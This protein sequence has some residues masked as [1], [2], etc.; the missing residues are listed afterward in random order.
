MKV[1]CV[2][3][4]KLFYIKPSAFKKLK[5]GKPTCSR[6]CLSELKKDQMKG[7]NN[8][9]YGLIGD[10]NSS[11]KNENTIN[12]YGYVLEYCPGHPRPHDKYVKG[13]RVKQHRLVIERNY[14]LFDSKYFET[15]N[16]FIV[17]KQEYDIHHMNGIKTDN[18]LENLEIVSRSEHTSLHNNTKEIIRDSTNGRIIG[19]L[20][21]GELLENPNLNKMDNQQPSLDSNILEG[22]T[23]NSQIPPDKTEDSNADKSALPTKW[24]DYNE[25]IYF[26]TWWKSV[27]GGDDI[28]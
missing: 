10:K 3:C 9:Q 22:S 12:N 15:I 16:N 14:K 2:I 8:H 28:V 5:W 18:R 19:V 4:N 13:C 17:L 7:I 24:I 11:F 21:Q 23:T 1:N 6:L 25:W 27:D 20:K 26:T